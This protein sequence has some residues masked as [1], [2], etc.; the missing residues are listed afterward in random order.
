MA[1]KEDKKFS[2]WESRRL[3]KELKKRDREIKRIIGMQDRYEVDSVILAKDVEKDQI[4]RELQETP[5]DA[6]SDYKLGIRYSAYKDAGYTSILDLK[7]LTLKQ[8]ERVDGI[9]PK[10]AENT[11]YAVADICNKTAEN[12][13]VRVNVQ[14]PTEKE[15]AL[16]KSLYQAQNARKLSDDV[17]YF[18]KETHDKLRSDLR[19]IAPTRSW[20]VWQFTPN[21]KKEFIIESLRGIKEFAED[22]YIKRTDEFLQK[23]YEIK[24]AEHK[25]YWKLFVNNSAGF[26]ATL[27]KAKRRAEGKLNRLKDVQYTAIRNG[28]P[29]ELAVAISEVPLDLRGLSANLYP[30]QEYGVQYILNQGAVLLGDDMGLGKTVQAIA[31]MVSLRNNGATHFMVVCPASVIINWC[32]EIEKFSDLKFIK[33]H[34]SKIDVAAQS[35][36]KDGGVA[37]TTYETLS[38]IPMAGDFRYD[39]LVVDEA[40]YV[41]NPKASR[42]MQL[43]YFRQH[44]DRV[45]FMSGTPL[46]NRVSEMVFLIGCL[47]P[48]VA[49]EVSGSTNINMAPDFRKKVS[50]VYFRRTKED[51]LEDLPDKVEKEEWIE[52]LP[53]EKKRYREFVYEENFMKLRQASWIIG[54]GEESSKLERLKELIEEYLL[55]GR[56]IIVFSFFTNTINTIMDAFPN[57]VYGPITGSITPARRQEI[58]DLFSDT[59][60]GGVL[61]AQ[62]QAGGTGL[63]IQAASVVIFCEPQLKPSIEEQAIAR[64]YRMGQNNTVMVHRLLNENTVDEQIVALLKEKKE[65]FDAF[66]DKSESGDES[67]EAVGINKIMQAEKERYK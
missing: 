19:T 32:R 28:L 24:K 6:L 4:V 66:A 35:W 48:N 13:K 36:Y 22:I 23:E 43:L 1:I 29:E 55:M 37:V 12:I 50:G 63:N 25:Y 46:E 45:L 57:E 2:Y 39:M 10:S 54:N 26:Y 67:L 47:Q 60:V 49:R 65:L 7:G 16:V 59:I 15:V 9:G 11:A 40:H 61:L 51:V 8:L 58:I 62:I 53:S 31:S 30:Y 17:E 34:G 44:T 52:L 56:K 21:D 27:E 3:I 5:V 14:N 42:T 18:Y 33:I 41:K 64:V 38:K 20:L